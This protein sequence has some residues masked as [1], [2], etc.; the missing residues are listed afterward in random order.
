MR[1]IV[2]V[3][4]SLAGHHAALTLRELGYDGALTV[5]GDEPHAPYDRWP[6]SN[7][8]LRGETSRAGLD[9]G[10]EPPDVEW[11]RGVV[12][13]WLD[14][15]RRELVLDH[16]ARIPF[17]GL[18]IA[19]GSRPRDRAA[20]AGVRGAF[21]LR[22]VEDATRLRVALS[23]DPRLVVVV[24]GG[25]IGAEV[26]DAAAAAG[27]LTTLVHGPDLPTS[28]ALGPAVAGHLTGLLRSCGVRL[29]RDRR[30]RSLEVRSGEVTGVVLDDCGRIPADVVVMAT[31]TRPNID[32]LRG[33]GLSVAGGL[34]CGPTLHALGV[35][36]VVAAGDV[37][38]L[39]HAFL[40]GQRV[41]V[42]H[43]ASTRDQAA[44]AA[45][46]LLAGPSGAEALTAL[47]EF[48]TAIDGVHVRCLGFPHAADSSRV[49]HGSLG[50]G[51]A[52]VLLERGGRPVAAVTLNATEGLLRWR[53]GLV[54]APEL[55]LG[56][57]CRR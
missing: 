41:R 24:G 33:S 52:V 2:V 53:D 19:C 3:G 25:L 26:A 13:T 54:T 16:V 8:Y 56:R 11:R 43:W 5:V 23:G 45:A 4:G 17:D 57:G 9:I 51:D 39:P 6:L 44:L 10:P 36:G 30:V 12:A 18:V 31:G 1:R 7:E 37:A 48:G 38:R 34:N 28:R 55:A 15:A 20:V 14:L 27:H 29:L 35:D 32:W 22:T 21:V 42:E 46:N 50:A 40:D 47:P 49:V